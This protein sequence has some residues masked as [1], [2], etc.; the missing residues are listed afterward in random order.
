M[1]LMGNFKLFTENHDLMENEIAKIYYYYR[2]VMCAVV[3]GYS[4][5]VIM[6][7]AFSVHIEVPC[8]IK[9]IT[10]I[11]GHFQKCLYK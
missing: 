9:L 7:L 4:S 2:Y 6:E 8:D 5:L 3:N 1:L 10:F 11:T